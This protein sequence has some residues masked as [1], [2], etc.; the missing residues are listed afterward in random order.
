MDFIKNGVLQEI[1]ERVSIGH[2]LGRD[3]QVERELKVLHVL[4]QNVKGGVRRE[5]NF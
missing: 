3:D 4:L 2:I 1:L 5:M